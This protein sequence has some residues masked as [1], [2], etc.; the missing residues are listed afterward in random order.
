MKQFNKLKRPSWILQK[1][2]NFEKLWL[3]KNENVDPEYQE[4]IS[5][6][7]LEIPNISKSTYPEPAILYK[8]LSDLDNVP[9]DSLFLTAGSDGAIR[10][11]FELFINPKDKI[12]ITTIILFP[13]KVFRSKIFFLKCSSHS[14]I[15]N[16]R[17]FCNGFN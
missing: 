6:V 17:F 4:F 14:T 15:N 10:Y 7:A 13:P 12:L 1:P 11:S 9:I 3:D 8:K 2:R 16:K 5:Q